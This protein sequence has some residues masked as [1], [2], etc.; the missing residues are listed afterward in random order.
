M[1]DKVG[2]HPLMIIFAL[3]SGGELL[4]IMGMMIAIPIAVIIK[5]LLYYIIVELLVSVDNR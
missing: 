2:L 3:L 1:G 5:E 4:G